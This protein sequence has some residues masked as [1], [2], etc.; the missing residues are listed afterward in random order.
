LQNRQ[1]AISKSSDHFA[2]AICVQVVVSH[3]YEQAR[4]MPLFGS[5]VQPSGIQRFLDSDRLGAAA[6]GRWN[7]AN[8]ATFIPRSNAICTLCL[9]NK[10]ASTEGGRDEAPSLTVSAEPLDPLERTQVSPMAWLLACL[11][12]GTKLER[13]DPLGQELRDRCIN[14]LIRDPPDQ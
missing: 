8:C 4:K 1:P 7:R 2:P 6:I 13:L 11:R 9:V 12:P 14:A 5:K 3:V 10:V